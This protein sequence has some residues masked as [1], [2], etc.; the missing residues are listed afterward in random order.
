M[1]VELLWQVLETET[2]A[3]PKYLSELF[4][5][6]RVVFNSS[7]MASFAGSAALWEPL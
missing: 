1:C 3:K 4:V 2:D 6:L 5:L 7:E